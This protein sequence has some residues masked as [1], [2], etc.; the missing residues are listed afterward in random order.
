MKD[1]SGMSSRVFSL[2]IKQ[3][4]PERSDRLLPW[5]YGYEVIAAKWCP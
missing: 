5:M 4:D 1:G 3:A 2:L